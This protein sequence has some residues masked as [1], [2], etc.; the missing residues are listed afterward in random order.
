[1][2]WRIKGLLQWLRE[3]IT[4]TPKK[5][6]QVVIKLEHLLWQATGGQCSKADYSINDMCHMV[7]DYFSECW[8]EAIAEAVTYC[9]DC[10]Y[11]K[12]NK[13]CIR[14]VKSGGCKSVDRVHA[15]FY[16]AAGKRRV[17]E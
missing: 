6:D 12:D 2:I 13:V 17:E 10:V 4:L 14:K 1:M 5:Y 7:N 8:D 3:Y 9:K 11:C 16:C 15:N